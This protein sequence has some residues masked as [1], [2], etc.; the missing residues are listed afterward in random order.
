M[1]M[2]NAKRHLVLLVCAVLL[3][4]CGGGGSEIPTLA[5]VTG[6][7]QFKGQP[8]EGVIVFF[9]PMKTT[10]TTGASGVT[11][12][13]GKYELLHRSGKP[14]IEPGE[15]AV[16]F[17]RLMLADGKPVPPG[18]SPTEAGAVETMPPRFQ[19]TTNPVHTATVP[20]AGGSFDFSVGEAKK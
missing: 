15:Y 18:I 19:D 13:D 20:D 1:S 8:T 4:G 16:T 14:G 7:V 9:S 17:S 10:Q 2:T 3:A 5:P 11:G 6:T 12:P